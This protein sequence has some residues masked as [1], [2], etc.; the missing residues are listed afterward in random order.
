M[1]L[2]AWEQHQQERVRLAAEQGE[3]LD[4]AACLADMPVTPEDEDPDLHDRFGF[5][6]SGGPAPV[7][8][9]P[10]GDVPDAHYVPDER[11]R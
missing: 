2:D 1:D 11:D 10:E 8:P 9:R 7:V 6:H 3:T 4:L 5:D